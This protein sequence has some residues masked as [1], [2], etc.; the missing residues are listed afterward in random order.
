MKKA[1][2]FSPYKNYLELYDY[3]DNFLSI[4]SLSYGITNQLL[5]KHDK[6]GLEG[7]ELP[8]P[9]KKTLSFSMA[10]MNVKDV[11]FVCGWITCSEYAKKLEISETEVIEKAETGVLGHKSE[12]PESGEC[13]LIWPERYK[14]KNLDEL[15]SPGKSKFKPKISIVAKADFSIDTD[16]LTGFEDK[17]MQLVRLAH[18]VGDKD[19]V[20]NKAETML[21]QS[22]FLLNWTAFEVFI[23]ETIHA[24]Y[25]MHPVKLTKGQKGAAQTLSYKDIF[26]M[27]SEFED[28]EK[29][30]FS[31]VE[32]EIEKH[33]K[34]GESI[35]GLI[36]FL[37]SEF[38]FESDPY[39]AWYVFKGDSKKTSFRR[40]SEIKDVRN[41]L[42][43]NAGKD[44]DELI[45]E[46]PHL[47]REENSLIIN[48]DYYYETALIMKSVAFSIARDIIAGK[49]R[50]NDC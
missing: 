11:E 25:R 22:C 26:Q 41:A 37:K 1:L 7:I 8:K 50:A 35:T 36:N 23:R 47:Q 21:F 3:I 19:K 32:M 15:P 29:L 48:E 30:K 16:E 28:I 40:I 46:Y 10:D 12:H 33:Q 14:D 2:N 31:L 39:N 49:Y 9:N 42:M 27:S 24:L 34:D 5:N 20:T 17:Q 6:A 44:V 18:A 38:K 13:L 45:E 4:T 43:H